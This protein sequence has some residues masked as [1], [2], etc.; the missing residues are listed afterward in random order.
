MSSELERLLIAKMTDVTEIAR[1]HELGLS[2][3]VFEEALLGH[4][5]DWVIA[6]WIQANMKAAPTPLAMVTKFPSLVDLPDT[7][8]ESG[9]FLVE[10]LRD[11]WLT[12]QLQ[13]MIRDAAT[14]SMETPQETM[15]K[16]W[17]AAYDASESVAPRHARVDISKNAEYRKQLYIHRR[18]QAPQGMTL[19]LPE[20]DAQTGGVRPGELAA[21]AAYTKV[22]KTFLLVKAAV[23]ARKKGYT[24]L[25]MT[26]EQSTD[27]I[28]ERID[29][30]HSGVSYER[31]QNTTLMP[32]EST[33]LLRARDELTG[34]GRFYVETPA[35]GDRTIKNITTRARMLGADYLIIDQLSFLDG[36]KQYW[37]D[38]ALTQK[39]GE[40]VF[41]LKDSIAQGS[42][43]KLPCFMAVQLNRDALK[44]AAKGTG[45]RGGL[46][47]FANSSVIEQTVDLALGLW[48]G[49]EARANNSMYLDIM[50]AR[51]CDN[52]SWTL[53]W[54]LSQHTE[55]RVREELVED[56]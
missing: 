44:G 45:A 23:E 8:E 35:R 48:R 39:H 29:A 10:S 37:G 32:D 38:K 26:L 54:H 21:V 3:V 55:I 19:G 30:M 2:S 25:V 47:N 36:E 28:G 7:V 9:Q 52:K 6:Y 41:D 46:H 42:L 51:R 56:Q 1:V 13:D 17:H 27:E 12:N 31:L 11:R 4:V 15:N 49:S 50:G 33:R 5:F 34:F 20:L 53:A 14:T 16:L 40:L 18:D 43:G 22:G 24:P